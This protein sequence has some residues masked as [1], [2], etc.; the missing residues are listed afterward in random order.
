M[1]ERIEPTQKT[2]IIICPNCQTHQIAIVDTT[3]IFNGYVHFCEK[4][5]YTIT[6]SEWEN[7]K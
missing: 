2:E 6:E 4:C 3:G 5:G 7:A 1:I